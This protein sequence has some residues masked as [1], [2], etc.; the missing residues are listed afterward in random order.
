MYSCPPAIPVA[1]RSLVTEVAVDEVAGAAGAGAAARAPRRAGS[2]TV[3]FFVRPSRPS[4]P[5]IHTNYEITN[6]AAA[7]ETRGSHATPILRFALDTIS[8]ELL[9]C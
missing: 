6:P 2:A 1:V 4:S 5:L 8:V 7:P 3:D 9:L